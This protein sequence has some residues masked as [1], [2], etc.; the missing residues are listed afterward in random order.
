MVC[1]KFTRENNLRIAK[2]FLK[3]SYGKDKREFI[4]PLCKENDDVFMGEKTKTGKKG[5][6]GVYYIEDHLPKD[7]C[8]RGI[9]V[10]LI[11]SH[12]EHNPVTFKEFEQGYSEDDIRGLAKE[13]LIGY[14]S[15]F[16]VTACIVL[17]LK[18]TNQSLHLQVQCEQYDKFTEEDIKKIRKNATNAA[19][20]V[21]SDYP[22]DEYFNDEDIHRI[23]HGYPVQIHPE[24]GMK[25]LMD[26]TLTKN[27]ALILLK[28][29]FFYNTDYAS[30]K[31]GLIEQGKYKYDDFMISCRKIN[32]GRREHMSCISG[33][34]N[35]F[36]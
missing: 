10:G 33:E 9:Q 23:L 27:E 30:L 15:Y 24:T 28:E 6:G 17:P 3:Y 22:W 35:L 21:P 14:H 25:K 36:A 12:P 5:L 19:I 11:H 18:E 4:S 16:P 8:E 32:V 1:L 29:Q 7:C 34:V 31:K 26:G 13:V 20:P 2:R